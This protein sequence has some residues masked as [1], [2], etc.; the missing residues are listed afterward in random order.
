MI[1]WMKTLIPIQTN[2]RRAMEVIHQGS[3]QLV[4]VVDNEN[5]LL[6]TLSDGDIRAALLKG[7]SLEDAIEPIMNRA[8]TVALMGTPQEEILSLMAN[9]SL[10]QIPIVDAQ[11]IVRGLELMDELIRRPTKPNRVILMAGGLGNRLRPLTE[12]CPKPLLKVRG[13]PILE[14]ILE[15][16]IQYGFRKFTLALNYK[17]EMIKDHFGDGSKWNS[18]IDYIVE[19]KKLGTAGALSML[20]EIPDEPFFVM[21]G[22]LITKA[23]FS[24]LLEFHINNRVIGSMCVQNYVV[25]VPYGVVQT[26]GIEM[27]GVLEKPTYEFLVNSGIYVFS[28]KVLE[29]LRK[30]EPVDIPQL[31]HRLIENGQRTCCFPLNSLWMD[32]A[33]EEDLLKAHSKAVHLTPKVTDSPDRLHELL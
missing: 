22:D 18:E 20:P 32:I 3:I 21:N 11:G 9:R 23:N 7:T 5:R 1:N 12:E 24:Q 31:F 8:P 27:L 13:R 29:Y 6:G 17:A 28:P 15:S 2:V 14:W 19:T 10:R 4:L 16:F 26:D 30:E 33:Y 25:E